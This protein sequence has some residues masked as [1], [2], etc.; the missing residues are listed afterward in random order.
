MVVTMGGLEPPLDRLS[1]CCL[2]Q[3]TKHLRRAEGASLR[4]ADAR[5]RATWPLVPPGGLE[6]PP[7]GL[8]TRRA[9]FTLRRGVELIPGIEPGRRPYQGRRLPLHQISLERMAGFEP[10]PQGLEGPQ[11]TATPHSHLVRP[12][13]IEPVPPRWQRGMHSSTPRPNVD[14][15]RSPAHRDPSVFKDPALCELGRQGI[16]TQSLPRGEQGYG[17]SADHPLV[18]PA[19]VAASRID[20]IQRHNL[21]VTWRGSSCARQ[22]KTKK[23]F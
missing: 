23:A 4:L 7:H 3:I 1:T 14:R 22:A 19:V 21:P 11:A 9:A 17:P 13:G 10:A 16:R 12:T 15:C 2:C 20:P 6:P 18:P 5:G 8:R